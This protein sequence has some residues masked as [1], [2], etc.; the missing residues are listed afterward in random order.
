MTAPEP[1]PAAPPP[2]PGPD[3]PHEIPGNVLQ[4]CLD[5]AAAEQKAAGE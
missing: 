4:Q 5:E 1:I 2:E 3:S